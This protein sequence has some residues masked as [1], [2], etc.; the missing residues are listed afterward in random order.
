M[1]K[2]LA[3][4]SLALPLGASADLQSGAVPT[5][6]LEA[7]FAISSDGTTATLD[8]EFAEVSAVNGVLNE[9]AATLS[10]DELVTF[11]VNGNSLAYNPSAS[12]NTLPV[13]T[14]GTYTVNYKRSNGEAY[15]ATVTL[16]D[17][18]KYSS[19]AESQMFQK[20]DA[21]TIM[22]QNVKSDLTLAMYT[23]ACDN[24]S[25]DVAVNDAFTQAVFPANYAAQCTGAVAMNFHVFNANAGSGFGTFSAI[26]DGAIDFSYGASLRARSMNSKSIIRKVLAA[27]RAGLNRVLLTNKN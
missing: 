10:S 17:V 6:Q 15:S 12:S 16:P 3:L 2:L 20:S 4:L 27:R 1:F 13:V 9:A 5:N 22:W 26:S 18:V 21:V 19:P 23:Q 24:V 14:G 7:T 8:V 25:G 11:T